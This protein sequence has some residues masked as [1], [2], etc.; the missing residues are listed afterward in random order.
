MTRLLRIPFALVLGLSLWFL[1]SCAPVANSPEQP[2]LTEPF[3]LLQFSAAMQLTAV[4]NQPVAS[5]Q[6]IRTLRVRPGVHT[7]RFIHVN[8]GPEGSADHAG[9]LAAP[10][11]LETHAGITYEF[12]AK[13]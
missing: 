7:L 11:T 2:P 4:D 9:Q 3:A 5:R 10:F 8:D 13:T 12:E 1:W 6:A